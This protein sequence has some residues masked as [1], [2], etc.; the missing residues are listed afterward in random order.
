MRRSHVLSAIA[1][2][3]ALAVAGCSTTSSG[4]REGDR[5]VT[6]SITS[7]ISRSSAKQRYSGMITNGRTGYVTP[8]V[9]PKPMF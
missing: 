7:D 8:R 3:L 4:F 1:A 6:S 9:E 5:T 2:I